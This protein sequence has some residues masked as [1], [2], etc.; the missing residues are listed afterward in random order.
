MMHL[1]ALLTRANEYRILAL[2]LIVLHGALWA[3]LEPQ[4]L[5]NSRRLSKMKR[6]HT[7]V[8][9]LCMI[10]ITLDERR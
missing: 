4:F 6:Q 8:T 5:S 10:R 2:M 1:T 3:D 7:L 9:A